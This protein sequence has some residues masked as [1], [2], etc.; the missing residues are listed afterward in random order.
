MCI[1]FCDTKCSFSFVLRRQVN[2]LARDNISEGYSGAEI[3]A[4]CRDAA[5][6]AIGEIDDGHLDMPRICM[7]HLF[8][9]ISDMKPRTTPEMLRLY[10]SCRG[11]H[12]KHC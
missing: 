1:L 7:Q 8:R 3:I 2:V 11:R 4:I 10:D 12:W 5:L 6:H 9:S